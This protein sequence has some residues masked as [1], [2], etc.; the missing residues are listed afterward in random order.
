MELLKKSL[1]DIERD[2]KTS[3]NKIKKYFFLKIEMKKKLKR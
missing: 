1:E 2:L 3:Y